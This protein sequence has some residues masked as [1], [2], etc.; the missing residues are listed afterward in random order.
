MISYF[1]QNKPLQQSSE[2]CTTTALV[3]TALH[4][5]DNKYRARF[6]F[7]KNSLEKFVRTN[8]ILYFTTC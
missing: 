2:A 1:V 7:Y 5:S 4:I 8:F 3:C 6:D